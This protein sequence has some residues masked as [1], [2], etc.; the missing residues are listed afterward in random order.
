MLKS[1]LLVKGSGVANG[2]SAV[3][4]L[5]TTTGHGDLSLDFQRLWILFKSRRKYSICV[6]LGCV[7]KVYTNVQL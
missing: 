7:H 3:S 6:Q 1:M 4:V 5:V 2:R